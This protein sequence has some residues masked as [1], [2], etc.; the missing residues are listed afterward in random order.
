[1]LREEI[2][3]PAEVSL[4]VAPGR[5]GDCPDLRDGVRPIQKS[6]EFGDRGSD[7]SLE[8]ERHRLSRDRVEDAEARVRDGGR[9]R[10]VQREFPLKRAVWSAPAPDVGAQLRPGP[11]QLGVGVFQPGAERRIT[12]RGATRE[13][14]ADGGLNGAQ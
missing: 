11:D 13:H 5:R 9:L 1:M 4:K 2:H 10:W 8:V 7:R 12:E 14:V 6:E 3:Q